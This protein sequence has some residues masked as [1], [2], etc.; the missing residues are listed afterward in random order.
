MP[1]ALLF[2]KR[3]WAPV[4]LGLALVGGYFYATSRID[5][6]KDRLET[7]AAHKARLEERMR[8]Y[9][10]ALVT[11]ESSR[12]QVALAYDAAVANRRASSARIQ[13]LLTRLRAAASGTG[14]A[15]P[16][17]EVIGEVAEADS[18]CSLVERGCADRV[19][20]E[21]RVTRIWQG[22]YAAL[23][24]LF[25]ARPVVEAPRSVRR[26]LAVGGLGA[27]VGAGVTGLACA[28]V[29]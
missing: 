27:L 7:E 22:K 19:A 24:S 5:A 3:H 25:R 2:L 14:P 13:D 12:V 8:A 20:A 11:A 9:D 10:A 6:W 17:P 29:R 23:D 28:L 26:D 18:A 16:L 4:L 15:V 1:V 21:A